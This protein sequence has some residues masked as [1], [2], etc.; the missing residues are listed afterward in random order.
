[1]ME[2]Y[3]ATA[4]SK[5]TECSTGAGSKGMSTREHVSE[6]RMGLAT[7]SGPRVATTGV[8]MSGDTNLLLRRQERVQH[9]RD[10][11]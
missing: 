7:H 2:R 11:N 8:N 3:A 6:T 1:M 5:Q 10:V 4:A 9:S